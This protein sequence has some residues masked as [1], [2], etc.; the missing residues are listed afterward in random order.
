MLSIHKY[1]CLMLLQ[2]ICSNIFAQSRVQVS[3]YV[4]EAESGECLIGAVVISGNEWA[5]TNEYGYYSMKVPKGERTIRC[6]FL[7]HY[8]EDLNLTFEKDT[9]LD[10]VMYPNESIEGAVAEARSHASVPSAYVGVIDLP[11]Q[12]IKAM[13]SLLGE[14]DLLKS[15]Q[16]MPGI[17]SGSAGFSGIYVRGGGAEENLVLMDGAP[18]YNA[19]HMMGLFSTFVPEAVKRVTVFKGF[20]PAKYGG[21]ASSVIDVRTNE[22]NAKELK[23]TVSVGLINSRIHLEGPVLDDKTTF[24]LSVRGTN[25]LVASPFLKST[26]YYFYDV[27]GKITRRLSNSDR[28]YIS[29]YH[30]RDHFK[31]AKSRTMPYYY[32]SEKGRPKTGSNTSEENYDLFWG[33][34]LAD[35]RWNHQFSGKV[36]SDL[37]V[38]WS[39]YRM[40]ENSYQESR[41]EAD[42]NTSYTN[43]HKNHSAIS[44]LNIVWDMEFTP[45]SV[46]ELSFG[47]SHTF[48]TFRPEKDSS[49]HFSEDEKKTDRKVTFSNDNYISYL[50]TES[51][52]YLEDKLGLGTFN[53]SIG[54]RAT[55]F[56]TSGKTYPSI[57]PRISAEYKIKQNLSVKGAYS[58][59]SQ[60]VHLLASGMMNLPTDLWV[61]ITKNIKPVISDQFSF[62]VEYSPAENWK[63]SIEAYYKKEKNVLE[64]KDGQLVFT[65]ATDWEKTVEMGNGK[66]KGLE[67]FVQ[68]TAGVWTGML[69]YTLS[70]TDRIFPD[71][72]IN[73]GKSFPF[74]YDRR[75]VL[76]CFIS[77]KVNEKISLNGS[78]SFSSGNMITASWRSTLLVDPDGK[79]DESAYIS[80]RNNYRLPPSHRLDISADFR[81]KKKHGERIWSFGIYNLYGAMN[82]DWVV[83]DTEITIDEHG[84]ASLI[85]YLSKRSFLTFIPSVSYTYV[86]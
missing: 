67:L 27:T 83:N 48:H 6:S 64:Y 47:V 29:A 40:K 65:S 35:I 41:V 19:S 77:Y 30:G 70:K 45:S 63:A 42:V 76:D 36:F 50:G 46:H 37:A 80:G 11:A 43:F 4:T 8:T 25:T 75:H 21:R 18:L 7:G 49:Q 38:S 71:G 55:L 2:L 53:A 74:T 16:K 66:G 39:D 57:E 58:R 68:K 60:Y 10:I 1:A 24:S 28:I 20:F 61:P 23:G 79:M 86:F 51:A 72:T 9:L 17:Q 69:G 33:N 81:K 52:I 78:W 22:G 62:G 82:P 73:Y 56:S 5:V 14:P 3:G 54:L 31:Y 26:S 15:L 59:M 34:N 32:Y 85:H 84:E 12:Y 44:D 13:P